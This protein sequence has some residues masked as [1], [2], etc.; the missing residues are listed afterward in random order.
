MN[1]VFG[2]SNI[3]GSSHGGRSS[4]ATF[5]LVTHRT[6]RAH[7]NI[8]LAVQICQVRQNIASAAKYFFLFPLLVV[9]LLFHGQNQSNFWI[10]KRKGKHPFARLFLARLRIRLKPIRFHFLLNQ[11]RPSRK[12]SIN[13]DNRSRVSIRAR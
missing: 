12:D 5:F 13:G 10:D 4:T 1:V 9:F 8:F 2:P 6:Q 3:S 7:G 11:S